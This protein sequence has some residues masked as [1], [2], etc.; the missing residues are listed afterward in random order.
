[1]RREFWILVLFVGL[2]CGACVAQDDGAV[3]WVCAKHLGRVEKLFDALDLDHPGLEDV[4]AAVGKKDWAAACN[5]LLAYYR[6]GK[7]CE[8]LREKPPATSNA[9]DLAGEEILKDVITV[10]GTKAQVPRR[11]DNGL[12]WTWGGAKDSPYFVMA[13]HNLPFLGLL[14]DVWA[15]TGNPAYVAYIDRS[16]RDWVLSNPYPGKRADA[17]DFNDRVW[18]GLS[19]SAR[20]ETFAKVFYAL[21]SVGAFTPATRIL[22]LSSIPDHA[23]YNRSFHTASSH[24]WI[25][26]E[27]KGLGWAAG[28][29]PEFKDAPEWMD[30]AIDR[31]TQEMERQIYPDGAQHELSS[32][33]QAYVLISAEHFANVVRPAGAS[34]SGGFDDAIKRIINWFA[35]SL[36]P[37]GCAPLNNDSDLDD[38]AQWIER[39]GKIYGRPDWLY[40]AT[41]GERGEYPGGPPSRMFPWAGQ[42]IMR[43]GYD[44]DAHWAFFDDG[45]WG[46]AHFHNDKLHLSVHA[47]GRDLLVDAGRYT[48]DPGPWVVYFH[49][50]RAHNVILIDGQGQGAGP[51]TTDRP[52]DKDLYHIEDAFDYARGSFSNFRDYRESLGAYVVER[53]IEGD[54]RHTRGLLY[55]RGKYWVVVDRIDTDRPRRIDC[56]WHYH[57]DCTVER[58]GDGV[59]STD[60]DVGNLRIEPV[61]GPTWEVAIV[62]GQTEPE[63]QG[64]Y[65]SRTN[66]KQPNATAVYSADIPRGSTTFAWLLLPAK[67]RVPEAKVRIVSD[68]QTGVVVRVEAPGEEATSIAVPL[69]AGKSGISAAN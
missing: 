29:F 22:M 1:M 51:L 58:Q 18:L 19:T 9:T 24:N 15:K 44:K 12:D 16:V 36:R 20:A 14:L 30:Y 4:K 54:A 31:M 59:V 5:T 21:Q 60:P 38:Y 26:V 32:A 7:T 47:F 52:L 27:M 69:T 61:G 6:N 46:K 37:D 2:V 13:L 34:L 45:P 63:V 50:S 28:G 10:G 39:R 67:G 35:Y 42:L 64:W 56:L 65:S 25:I 23:H 62:K 17:P 40:I 55:V 3:E 57:P 41:N 8:W 68:D 66:E 49:S 53:G 43:N 48:Y 33:Y 11:P